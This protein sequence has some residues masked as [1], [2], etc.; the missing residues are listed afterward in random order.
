MLILKK[1]IREGGVYALV[2]IIQKMFGFLLLPVYT[3]NMTSEEYGV[4]E[5]LVVTVSIAE[6][7]FGMRLGQAMSKFYYQKDNRGWQDKVVCGGLITSL[8]VNILLMFVFIL[9]AENISLLIFKDEKYFYLVILFSLLLPINLAESHGRDYC[10]ITSKVKEYLYFSLA[11]TV[12]QV[13]GVVLFV[14]ILKLGLMGVVYSLIGSSLIS[15][16]LFQLNVYKNVRLDISYEIVKKLVIFSL[17]LWGAASVGVLS[18]TVDKYAITS[19]LG[20]SE[21]G[22]YSLAAKFSA[23]LVMV[24]QPIA[25][26]WQPLRFKLYHQSKCHADMSDLF[27]MV[28][29]YILLLLASASVFLIL[30]GPDLIRLISPEEYHGAV[31]AVAPLI[32]A[33]VFNFSTIYFSFGLLLEEKTIYML[34]GQILFGFSVVLALYVLLPLLGIF[35]AALSILIGQMIRFVWVYYHSSKIFS[36][37]INITGLMAVFLVISGLT[38]HIAAISSTGMGGVVAKLSLFISVFIIMTAMLIGWAE[39]KVVYKNRSEILKSI[40]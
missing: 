26:V 11:K 9:N 17:P 40:F 1:F 14:I 37:N 19:L 33:S 39:L 15:A 3:Y 10:R 38:F 7:L 22:Q 24:W 34:Y 25:M 28:F 23:L 8:P 29:R 21:M 36:V 30:F 20:L 6:A 5:M 31:I 27:G 4:I 12:A 13:C 2:S 32:L 16:T 18:G 35:G